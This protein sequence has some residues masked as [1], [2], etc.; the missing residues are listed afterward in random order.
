MIFISLGSQ[1]FQFNRVLEEMDRL[2]KEKYI[3]CN[4]FAQIGY[5]TYIPKYYEYSKFLDKNEYLDKIENSSIVV[6][7]GGT[8]S[9]IN[10]VKK[11]KKVIGIPRLE[12]YGE[13]VDNH[14]LDIIDQFAEAELI[15]A[16]KEMDELLTALNQVESLNFR[17]YQSNTENV[18]KI[19]E[20]YLLGIKK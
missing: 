17:K 10:S 16:I 5:S 4:V 3:Q 6:T 9:I 7:H 14:Q 8:G 13:H 2:I 20:E 15:Y 19:L 18:I 11:E 12:K 1:K